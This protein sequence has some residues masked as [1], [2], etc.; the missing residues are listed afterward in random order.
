MNNMRTNRSTA[1]G[2]RGW[3]RP[4][5]AAPA[6]QPA[7]P[8]SLINKHCSGFSSFSRLIDDLTMYSGMWA[9]A[10]R[11]KGLARPPAEPA[12]PA[13]IVFSQ[14]VTSSRLVAAHSNNPLQISPSHRCTV[15]LIVLDVAVGSDVLGFAHVLGRCKPSNTSTRAL[16]GIQMVKWSET[17]P[18]R[19]A[20]RDGRSQ[21]CPAAVSSTPAPAKAT[22]RLP[23]RRHRPKPH[24]SDRPQ[25]LLAHSKDYAQCQLSG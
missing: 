17:F 5:P 24:S 15:A 25:N 21:C 10:E 18:D 14:W 6:A 8:K 4:E 20:L 16:F 3:R 23:A 1:R 2:G 12:E 11:Y 22:S 19:P 9:Y 7:A 13:G